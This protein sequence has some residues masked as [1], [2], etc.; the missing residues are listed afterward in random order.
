MVMVM[1]MI[2]GMGWEGKKE[3]R[4]NFNR[5]QYTET[6]TTGFTSGIWLACLLV[7]FFFFFFSP[8]PIGREIL[9]FFFFCGLC[10]VFVS[11]LCVCSLFFQGIGC[12]LNGNIYIYI[13]IERVGGGAGKVRSVS[14][15]QMGA[16]FFYYYYYITTHTPT[17]LLLL[18]PLLSCFP[19]L[20]IYLR[21]I[22]C[23]CV[24]VCNF[25]CVS[26]FRRSVWQT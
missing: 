5:N 17:S 25:F 19:C 2:G 24:C 23:V 7:F 26:S 20:S 3:S 1:V 4:H 10:G 21:L 6:K 18:F 8:S 11:Q 15:C 9:S 13:Y 12:L 22:M 16:R 14:F